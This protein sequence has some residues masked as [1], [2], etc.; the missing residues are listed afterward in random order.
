MLERTSLVTFIGLA[1]PADWTAISNNLEEGYP[2]NLGMQYFSKPELIPESAEL[3][4][5][6][7]DTDHGR[8]ITYTIRLRLPRE[9][10]LHTTFRRKNAVIALELLNGE[11]YLLGSREH[12]MK[13]E[14]TRSSGMAI[15]DSN[16][17][18]IT[19]TGSYPV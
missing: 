16:D 3:S 9:A 6:S 7:S 14:Y 15:G 17:T 12:P 13:L 11:R 1:D 10:S 18:E 19:I 2:S 5:S 4:E 8:L